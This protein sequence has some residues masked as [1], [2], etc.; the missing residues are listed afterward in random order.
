M[1][2]KGLIALSLLLMTLSLWTIGFN[3]GASELLQNRMD[4]PF[5][6]FLMVKIESQFANNDFATDLSSKLKSDQLKEKYHLQDHYYIPLTF[7][8]F[9]STAQKGIRTK[10]RM[11]R[12]DKALYKYLFEE[13]DILS[14]SKEGTRLEASSWSAIVSEEFIENLGYDLAN[15]PAQ[16]VYLTRPNVPVPISVLG[17]AKKLPDHSDILFSPCAFRAIANHCD[18]MPFD[19]ALDE[20]TRSIQYFIES[21]SSEGDIK[22]LLNKAGIEDYTLIPDINHFR[23]GWT[24]SYGSS[25]PEDCTVWEENLISAFDQNDSYNLHKMLPYWDVNGCCGNP[26]T[27]GSF[28][29]VLIEMA[30]LDSVAQF[31]EY[32]N[33]EFD[34]NVDLNEIES[35]RNFNIFN[36]ISSVLSAVLS[37]LTVVLIIYIL[38][39]SIIEHINENSASLGTLKA[40]G[41]TNASINLVYS[42]VATII[43]LGIYITGFSLA[44]LV[45]PFINYALMGEQVV[46]GI[47]AKDVFSLPFK[48]IYLLEFIVFPIGIIALLVIQKL[49]GKTPGDLVYGR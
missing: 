29:F 26:N 38:S 7:L 17:I 48:I 11:I 39:R 33:S 45:G 46:A 30:S 2:K 43:T 21:S 3:N 32:M 42:G 47:F 14:Y 1:R 31:A 5:I 36:R 10:V 27:D 12:E 24:I 35:S 37:L 49:R 6:K 13:S 44:F 15:P 25:F 34:L 18:P 28:D 22:T 4:S 9:R 19:P 41:L 16:I 8:E 40:F 20:Y 23:E